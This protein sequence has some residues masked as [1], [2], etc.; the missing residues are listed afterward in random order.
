MN[1]AKL[2]RWSLELQEFYISLEF[3]QEKLNKIMDVFLRLKNERLYI[4]HLHEKPAA[5]KVSL[6]DRIE[7]ILDITTNPSNFKRVFNMS[8]VINIKEPLHYQKGDKFCR[9]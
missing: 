8:K 2:D 5:V 3:I 6:Q 9:R 1:I 7:E 4:E